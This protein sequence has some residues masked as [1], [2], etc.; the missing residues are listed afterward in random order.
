MPMALRFTRPLSMPMSLAMFVAA[1]ALAACSGDD[2]ANRRDS[3]T[4][5]ASFFSEEAL[6][7]GV[8]RLIA[9]RLDELGIDD[10]RFS[11]SANRREVRVELPES[12]AGREAHKALRSLGVVQIRLVI[13][14]L[15]SGTGTVTPP[16][17]AEPAAEVVLASTAG[18]GKAVLYRLGPSTFPED[19]VASASATESAPDRFGISV[20]LTDAGLA[21]L[22]ALAAAHFQEQLAIVV[23]DRVLATPSIQTRAFDRDFLITGEFSRAE[24]EALAGRMTAGPIHLLTKTRA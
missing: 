4:F 13:A 1:L 14:A 12:P 17:E 20:S 5:E 10:A 21:S 16:G 15:P 23:D 2:D 19:G 11:I 18:P 7:P 22:N 9:S 3:A 8:N 6:P 24:A